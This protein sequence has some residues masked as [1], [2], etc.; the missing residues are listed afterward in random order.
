[1]Y[2]AGLPL[3]G[4]D[5]IGPGGTSSALKETFSLETDAFFRQSL[6]FHWRKLSR[7]RDL[8]LLRGSGLVR[9]GVV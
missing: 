9:V 2:Q 7:R 6:G 3:E 1:M 5:V 4:G 8:A